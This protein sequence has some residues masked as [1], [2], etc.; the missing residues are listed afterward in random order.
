[1]STEMDVME[2]GVHTGKRGFFEVQ[3]AGLTDIADPRATWAMLET[4]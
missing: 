3:A 1:M 2:C 4:G